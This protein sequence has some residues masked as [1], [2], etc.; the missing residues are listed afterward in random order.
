MQI[1]VKIQ[2]VYGNTLV[3]PLC[4]KSKLFAE[5]AGTK[6]LTMAALTTIKKLGYA[7]V[8]SKCPSF[9]F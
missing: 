9:A 3:Y 6:T 1:I 8:E 7:I 2:Q 4:E 5:L